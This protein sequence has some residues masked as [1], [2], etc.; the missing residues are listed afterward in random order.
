MAS[1]EQDPS[2]NYNLIR[3]GQNQGIPCSDCGSESGHRLWCPVFVRGARKPV[4]STLVDTTLEF[5][6]GKLHPQ[7]ESQYNVESTPLILTQA[8]QLLLS[9]MKIKWLG[10]EE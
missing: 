10:V 6:R 3:A 9:E 4:Q 1:Y 2:D 5:L 8:D 7:G